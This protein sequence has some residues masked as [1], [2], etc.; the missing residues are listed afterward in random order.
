M[1]RGC[2]GFLRSF[3]SGAYRPRQITDLSYFLKYQNTDLNHF[4]NAITRHKEDFLNSTKRY[5]FLFIFSIG[6]IGFSDY[7]KISVRIKK[8]S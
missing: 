6:S 4:S 2:F 7:G 5:P 1:G 3:F 8:F